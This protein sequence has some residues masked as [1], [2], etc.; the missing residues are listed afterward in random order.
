MSHPYRIKTQG[1]DCFWRNRPLSAQ[2]YTLKVADLRLS[3]KI[4][5][6]RV[7][8]VLKISSRSVYSIKSYSTFYQMTDRQTVALT[9]CL[10]DTYLS[11]HIQTG[12]KFYAHFWYLFTLQHSLCSL[13]SWRIWESLG[14][15]LQV[16]K[17]RPSELEMFLNIKTDRL[18]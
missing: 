4:Y 9:D 14:F 2:G 5:L 13:R 15:I 3:S 10:T 6:Y 1:G 7:G 8:L 12:T 17:I 16:Y 18:H 11:I